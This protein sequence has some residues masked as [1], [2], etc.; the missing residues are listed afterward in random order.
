MHMI[1]LTWFGTATIILEVDGEKLLFDPFFRRNKKLE[2]PKIDEFCNVDYIFNTHPHFDH[3]CDM[4]KILEK[5][6]AQFYGCPVAYNRLKAQC[7]DVDNKVN[8]IYVNDTI[9]TKNSQIKVHSSKHITNDFGIILKTALQT[10]FKFKIHKAVEIL[11]LHNDFR[12]GGEI[13]AFEIDADNKKLLLFG[14][15]GLDEKAN[16]PKDVDVLIWPYQGRSN[17]A[18]YSLPIIEK[19]SPKLVV[20]DHFDDA[21]PPITGKVNI[22]K[23]VKIMKKKHPEI[24]VIVPEYKKSIEL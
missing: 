16:L 20:L 8:K 17:M 19:I 21:F 6:E 15:A 13:V 1:K 22:S 12:M 14:S 24:G 10:V 9:F 7:V 23:F 11:S 18:K 5:T 3:L 4:P 2:Q